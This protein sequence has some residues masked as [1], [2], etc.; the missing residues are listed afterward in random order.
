MNTSQQVISAADALAGGLCPRCGQEGYSPPITFHWC[1]DC[2][3]QCKI[4]GKDL[5]HPCPNCLRPGY[6]GN[7][8]EW[9]KGHDCSN[10][11]RAWLGGKIYGEPVKDKKYCFGCGQ[12]VI[13]LFDR[14]LSEAIGQHELRCPKC[15]RSLAKQAGSL[16]HRKKHC[17][18]C[19]EDVEAVYEP[20][21]GCTNWKY[22]CPKCKQAIEEVKK[23]R[24]EKVS[25][26]DWKRFERFLSSA[27]ELEELAESK[28][29]ENV[30][31]EGEQ[32]TVEYVEP[33]GEKEKLKFVRQEGQWKVRLPV[34][35]P[36]S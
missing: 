31:V 9:R 17:Q 24:I 19:C 5:D 18:Q 22:F 34:P 21:K 10:C 28:K 3:K 6:K 23:E 14:K 36:K 30:K 26:K 16:M 13:P 2:Y 8:K 25:S 4:C 7:V 20:T 12:F 11:G 27:K 1:G 35:K 32:A 33:N 29:I 15:L